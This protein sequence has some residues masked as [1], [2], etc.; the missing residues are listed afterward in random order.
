[1]TIK[2]KLLAWLL[3]ALSYAFKFLTP[4]I[5]GYHYLA[6][7]VI[8]REAGKGGAFWYFFVS[9][10]VTVFFISMFKL[11]NKM[12]ANFFK[13][14][15]RGLVNIGVVVFLMILTNYISYNFSALNKV[16]GFTVSGVAVGTLFEV[17]AVSFY[18]QYFR[19]AGVL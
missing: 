3:V 15:F 8:A 2:K 19:E 9:I 12:K 11:V 6:K 13:S 10:L 18:G 5:A 1:M 16:L 17:A 7:D 14:M 4:L